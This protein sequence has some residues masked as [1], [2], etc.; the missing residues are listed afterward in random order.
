M[1]FGQTLKT[2]L[3]PEWTFHYIAYDD[4]K[5]ILKKG[6][7]WNEVSESRFIERLEQELD[8]V[9]NFQRVK[10]GE[11]QRRI[12]AEAEEVDNICKKDNAEDE[13][14]AASEIELGHI[15]ADVHDLA[16]FN[17]LNYTGFLKII[18]KHDV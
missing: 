9:Y 4:L 8:K 2:S 16:K 5:S 3:N 11:I 10:F 15:I 7:P 6:L 17:R 18:K 1:K 12:D 13:E 14:F